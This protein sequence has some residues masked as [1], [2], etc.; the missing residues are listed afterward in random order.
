MLK[1]MNYK[2]AV[3]TQESQS[4]TSN[5]VEIKVSE[6]NAVRIK[7]Y[8]HALPSGEESS[9]NFVK[10]MV[11]DL[12]EC[13]REIDQEAKILTWVQGDEKPLHSTQLRLLGPDC[14]SKYIHIPGNPSKRVIGRTYYQ[15]GIRV[16]TKFKKYHFIE[17]WNNMRY[18]AQRDPSSRN[19]IS[20]KASEVQE[21]A[22]AHTVGYFAGSTER[23]Y[24]DTLQEQ[25]QE[26]CM[27]PVEISY[28]LLNQ[29]TLTKSLWREARKS[30]ATAN[31]DPQSR[32]YKTPFL[33]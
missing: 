30:A 33:T 25:L 8:F 16:K 20:I 1:S 12:A 3:V 7:F 5:Q 22:E 17:K 18:D 6:T 29:T 26:M 27:H 31:K 10:T 19:W 2:N 15:V 23:G 32:A 14:V 28:Q 21:S 24:Y 11:M 9:G 13:A 4:M